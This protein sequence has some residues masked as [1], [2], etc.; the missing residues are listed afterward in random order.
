MYQFSLDWFRAIFI[1]S[2]ELTNALKDDSKE[3]DEDVDDT[4]RL[5]NNTF[6]VEDRINLLIKTVTQEVYKKIS[7]SVFEED[8]KLVTYM[9]VMR[10]LEAESFVDHNLFQF[11]INGS[12]SVSPTTQ[13]PSSIDL[14][15][16][17]WLDNM[18]WADLQYLAGVK[19]FNATNLLTH[20]T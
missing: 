7:M 3:E 16:L 1:K 5:L 13:V 9:L 4:L 17:P 14:V 6:S 20:F 11:L 12:K 10:V 19:P 8:R 15:K 2:L 18:M